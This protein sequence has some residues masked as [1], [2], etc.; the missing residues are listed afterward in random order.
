MLVEVKNPQQKRKAAVVIG[1]FNPPTIGH[2]YIFDVVK[3]FIR[4]NENLGLDFVPVVVVI[5]GK[6]TSLDKQKNPL[7]ADE[8]I[9]FMK[10]SGRADGVKFLT[11]GSAIEA[12]DKVRQAG[13]EPIA[14]ATGSDRGTKYIEMLDKYFT[15]N[16]GSK[17]KHYPIVVDRITEGKADHSESK[18][19]N[20][21]HVLDYLDDDIPINMISASL[22][23]RAVHRNLLDKFAIIVGLTK[24]MDVAKIM[25]NKIKKAFE[26][27]NEPV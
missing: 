12:F 11:A 21:D 17:I 16:D 3:S 22:A 1:R 6:K 26:V 2:Y 4:D 5:A 19:Q 20:L 24:K 8:R 15:T 9:S 25:F 23:R 14:V 7:S 18:K 10:A 27:K 13:F